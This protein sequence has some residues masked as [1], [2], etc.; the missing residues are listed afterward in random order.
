MMFK[1][2]FRRAQSRKRRESESNG[3][4]EED[5]GIVVKKNRKST[6]NNPMFQKTGTK[7]ISDDVTCSDSDGDEN[8]SKVGVAYRSTGEK[9]GPSDMGATATY[10]LDTAFDQD[11]QA[12]AQK[13]IDLNKELKGQED[14]A[15]I[16]TRSTLGRRDQMTRST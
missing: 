3:S 8:V 12:I 2:S 6:A 7:K 1:Q 11:A 4:S 9:E 16:T 5:S 10:E 15:Q 13:A 14:A